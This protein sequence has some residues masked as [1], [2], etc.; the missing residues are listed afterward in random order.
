M[1]SL[2][3]LVEEDDPLAIVGAFAFVGKENREVWMCMECKNTT[4]RNW[5]HC[6]R[7]MTHRNIKF[8]PPWGDFVMLDGMCEILIWLLFKILYM[9]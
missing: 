6:Q 1:E 9:I 3:S 2:H 8:Y 7:S 5:F 4:H